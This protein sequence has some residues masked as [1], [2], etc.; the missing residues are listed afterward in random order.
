[1][2]TIHTLIYITIIVS[3]VLTLAYT[4]YHYRAPLKRAY[5]EFRMY[6]E[7]ARMLKALRAENLRYGR[8]Y[9]P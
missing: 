5:N 1:M 9:G 2:T 7:Q 8:R 6:R 4:P 3:A